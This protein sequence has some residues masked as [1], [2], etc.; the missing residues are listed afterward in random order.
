MVTRNI[1]KQRKALIDYEEYTRRTSY[2]IT[3]LFRKDAQDCVCLY[4]CTSF[5]GSKRR[6]QR[7]DQ[8]DV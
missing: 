4:K 3:T 5:S 8:L 1:V 6:W 7:H 2:S